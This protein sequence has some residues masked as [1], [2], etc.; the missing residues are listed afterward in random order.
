MKKNNV[1][2]IALVVF[3]IVASSALWFMNDTRKE[4]AMI[5]EILPSAERIKPIDGALGNPFIQENFPAIE[6][7][8]SI[9]DKPAAFIASGTGY[10]G[11]IKVLIVMHNREEKIAGIRVLE[12]GD[13]PLYADSIKESWFTDKFKGLG[14]S[15]YLNRVILDPQKPTDIVQVTGASLSSQAVINNVNSALGAWNYF[16][17]NIKMNPVENFISQEMW[18]KDENSF[19]ISWPENN[20]IRITIE[21]LAQYPQVTT[22]TILHKTTGIKIDTKATGPLLKDILKKNGIDINVY[23][24]IGITGRDNYYAMISKDIIENRDIILGTIIDDKELPREE[25][26]VRIVIPEEMGPYWVKSVN[27]IELYTQISPKNIQNVH[28]F[29]ALTKDIEPYYYEYYG[30]KDKSFLVGKILSKFDFV[31]PNGF[32]TM[33]GSDGLVK[34]ET[35]NMVRDRYYIKVEGEN[36]PMNIGPGFKLGMNVKEMSH[37]STT[38][39]AVIFPNI[40]MKVIGEENTSSGKAMKLK[41]A[42]EEA[43]MVIDNEDELSIVDMNGKEYPISKSELGN[44]YLMPAEHG[45]DAILGKITVKDVQKIIKIQK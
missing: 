33:A 30:S 38:I 45:A 24:G 6:K 10:E 42:L 25:K 21:D 23:E 35:I 9:D 17:A 40:M 4:K 26:P 18:Q 13:T 5:K 27:K 3:L 2:I 36:S 34:N 12:Q 37:F 41:E 8:Y 15:E 39:D 20:S 44:A 29:G 19:M 14:L 32:F 43:G 31:D 22:E 16:Y 1:Y 11:T 7:I 28:I